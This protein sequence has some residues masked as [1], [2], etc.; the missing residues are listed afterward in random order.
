MKEV[1]IERREKI[2][3]IAV[4]ENNI[5][6][7]CLVEEKKDEPIIGEIYKGKVK[8]IIPQARAVFIDIGLPK[9]GYLYYGDYVIKK[10]LKKGDEVLAQVIKEQIENKGAKLS[11]KPS[12]SGKY[13][14]LEFY[15]EGIEFSKRIKD[16]E[17]IDYIK[18]NINCPKNVKVIIRTE[19]ENEDIFDIQKEIDN[20]YDVFLN[21]DRKLTYSAGNKKLYGDNITLM[22]LLTDLV[23]ENKVKIYTDNSDDYDFIYDFVKEND[24][25]ETNF[26]KDDISLFDSFGIE[27][28]LLKLRHN[29]VILPCGG[30]I[31][32]DKTEAMFVIDV[33]SG[34]NVKERNFNK[35]ILETNLEAAKEIG[36]QIRLRN[37]SGIILIDF[38]DFR[39]RD[40]RNKVMQKLKESLKADKGNVK[41]FPFTELDLVQIARKRKG[42]S[43]Y[44]YMEEKCERC[45]GKGFIL[46]LSYL[47]ELIRNDI[48]KMAKENLVKSFHIDIDTI[49]EKRIRE[50]ILEFLK[51]IDSLDMEI[52]LTFEEK[53]EG[54][55]VEPLLFNGQK[56]KLKK[57]KI[58][59]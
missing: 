13:S 6:E 47:E 1:F 19:S 26:Y 52:Y 4:K 56:E 20:L 23:G 16:K 36:R 41:I 48:I 3:R 39:D 21:L 43:I 33:N 24:N 49:Y 40:G 38:I 7:E 30:S 37:L 57:Y 15:D 46:K 2:L 50:N 45:E 9:E 27:R 34:K 53:L 17:K 55:K 35:T 54:Y 58:E 42:K 10:G 5:L 31:V 29:K 18:K 28:E 14:V 59:Y 32:I 11:I 51:G 8:N 12:I 44:E 22:K 25:F